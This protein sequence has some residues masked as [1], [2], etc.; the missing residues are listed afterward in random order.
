M[1]TTT[2]TIGELIE[3]KESPLPLE[4]IPNMMGINLCSVEAITWT[5]Q[6]DGQL[7]SLSIHFI[8]EPAPEPADARSR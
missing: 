2:K 6:Q 3:T 8:P 7:V 4:V 5:R 1:K